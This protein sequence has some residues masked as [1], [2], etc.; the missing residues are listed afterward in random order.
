MLS[1]EEII[2]EYKS[3]G[4]KKLLAPLFKK[5]ND[6]LFGLA[7]YYLHERESAM[8][9]VMDVFEAILISIDKKD[10]TYFKGWAMGICRNICLK[11]IRDLKK[12]D[13]LTETSD[14]SVEY[15][16]DRVYNDE[17]IEKLLE[18]I[19]ELKENQRVCVRDFYLL[20][21]SY[22]DISRSYGMSLK[23]VKSYIQNGKR[24]LKIKFDKS[25][26]NDM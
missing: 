10:I 4:N 13:E 7:F 11:K 2:L 1:D 15:G 5:Y 9:T 12:F 25:A 3:T 17:T 14:N 16:S 23:E 22:D 24:N 6:K 21:K 18:Y 20:G 8:D 19:P 26:I